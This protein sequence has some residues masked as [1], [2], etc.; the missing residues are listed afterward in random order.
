VRIRNF[1]HKGLKTLYEEDIAK[2]APPESVNKLRK[3]LAYL[4]TSKTLQNC[5]FFRFGRRIR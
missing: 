2:S 3:M 5:V 4:T 1:T